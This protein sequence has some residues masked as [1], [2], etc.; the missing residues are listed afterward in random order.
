VKPLLD[1]YWVHLDVDV[2]DPSIMPAVDSPD[3]GGLR[4]DE[5]A[6]IHNLMLRGARARGAQVTIYDPVLDPSRT[7]GRLLLELLGAAFG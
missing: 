7:C 3:P 2:L 5:L 4:R 1:G 6:V